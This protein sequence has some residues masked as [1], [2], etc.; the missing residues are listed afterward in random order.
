MATF[1]LLDLH[2]AKIDSEDETSTTY[3]EVKP[4]APAMDVGIQRTVNTA[5]LRGDNA[6]KYTASSK[7][8]AQITLNVTE[9]PKEV[10]ADLLG[11]KVAENGLL[12]ES[13]ED[14]A[15]YVA[16]GFKAND[17]RGGFK[18]IW[19]YRVK[20][21]VGESTYATKQETPEFN[22][23]TLTGN[24]I[25]RLNDGAREAALWDGDES[26]TDQTIFDEWF[27]DVVDDTWSGID[28][29]GGSV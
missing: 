20:F 22:N 11:K 6:V 1:G 18:Y 26:V 4:I 21:N 28:G 14:E 15:P 13:E 17:A 7:A 25:G 2:Y 19:L 24:S 3:G 27:N 8:P 9:L 12:I 16:F 10:E 29:G 5:N 23:P